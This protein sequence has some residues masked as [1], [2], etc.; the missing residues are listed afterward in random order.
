MLQGAG[1]GD[2]ANVAHVPDGEADRA[3]AHSASSCP[4][5]MAG[6]GADIL[7][8]PS[9]GTGA[10]GDGDVD[11]GARSVAGVTGV[12]SQEEIV[13]MCATH[14]SPP[15]TTRKGRTGERSGRVSKRVETPAACRAAGEDGSGVQ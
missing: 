10:G 13:R 8:P 7:P 9:G 15:R 5:Q 4:G 3:P 2:A 1:A 11:E 14:T 12:P 6:A